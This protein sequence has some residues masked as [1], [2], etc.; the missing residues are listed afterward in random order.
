MSKTVYA[1]SINNSGD[2]GGD[3]YQSQ[4]GGQTWTD[5]S[6]GVKD[7]ASGQSWTHQALS[8]SIDATDT[9][10]VAENSTTNGGLRAYWRYAAGAWTR[11]SLE[12]GGTNFI[13]QAVL[14]VAAES[15]EPAAHLCI[16]R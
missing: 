10:Y 4:D 14:S 3:V 15:N 8:S 5:I 2:S 6:T 1:V 12:S 7:V 16:G 9:L 11:F 13:N